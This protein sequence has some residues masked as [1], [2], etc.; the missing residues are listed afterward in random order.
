MRRC[1]DTIAIIQ[2]YRI[3]VGMTV[4]AS[5]WPILRSKHIWGDDVLEFKP[6][7]FLRK[8]K[9]TGEVKFDVTGGLKGD[10][11]IYGNLPFGAGYWR[12]LR[13]GRICYNVD[14][15][16]WKVRVVAR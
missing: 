7:R 11:A 4:N 16:S 5:P 10:A 9:A 8:N 2:G 1:V 6:E 15:L 14:R 12:A 13:K 3:P